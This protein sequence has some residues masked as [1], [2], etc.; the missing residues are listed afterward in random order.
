M[1]KLIEVRNLNIAYGGAAGWTNVVQGV[2]FEIARGEA[3]GLVGESGCG[4]STV[5]YRLLGYGTINSLVQTGEI[6][7]DGTD[8]LKL[9]ATALTRLRGDR[10]ALVP[11]NPTTSLSPGMRVGTQVREMI[12]THRA[13]PQGMTME[14]RIVELFALVGLPDVGHCYPHELSGGQQQRVTI[15]MAVACNPDLL[16]L[17][18]PTTGLDVTT[19]RQIIQ[20]LADLRARIGM[21]MLYVTHDLALL[22]QIADRVG[23]M[24]A[25]QL[26]EV[27]PCEEL[28][29][30]PAHPYSRGLIASIPTTDGAERQ[31]RGLRGVLRRDQMSTGC[32]FEPRCDFATTACRTMPQVLEPVTDARSVACMRWRDVVAP[33]APV[34][35]KRENKKIIG[36]PARLLSVADLNLSY[37]RP[38]L[39]DRLL[40]RTSPS[41]VRDIDLELYAGEVVALVGESGSGKSTIARAISGRLPP[42]TGIIRLDG[43]AL[44]PALK[45]RSVEELR[46]IQYIFQNPDASLNPRR[47]IRSILERPIDHF[48]IK[49]DEKALESVLEN[50]GLHAGYLD[51]FPEQLSGGERQRIAIA[52]A[53]LV[54]PKLLICDEILSALDVSVQARI[55]ELLR[56]LKEKHAVAMLFISHDLAVVQEFADRVAV[57]YRGELMQLADIATLLDAPLHPYTEMLLEAAPGLRRDHYVSRPPAF[58]VSKAIPGVGCPLAGRCPRQVGSLCAETRPPVQVSDNGFIRCHLAADELATHASPADHSDFA[59]QVRSIS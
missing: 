12:A 7:F 45:D 48:G 4:K 28:L 58:P 36:E 55:V 11:Q 20:L 43:A 3:F 51:R 6:I 26:V 47:R 19:Q 50:V 22:A 53:L 42:R 39:F 56:S 32:K 41:V 29:S 37:G 49:V 44:A 35:V 52:R 1:Q 17:D 27:A 15:A 59:G 9:G 13:L 54:N 57:L 30:A 18:E 34:L 23:V 24:Y 8:L 31:G 21:A 25:G 10:I 14:A 33:Q 46:Q 40:G 38:G 16:V 2:S 5:A